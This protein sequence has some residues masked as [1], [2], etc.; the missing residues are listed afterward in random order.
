MLVREAMTT[1]VVTVTPQITLR[2]AARLL[3]EHHI[4]SM[5]VLDEH[6]RLLGVVS[7]ADVV[8]ESLL[9]DQR[10]HLL[11][12]PVDEGPD[13]AYVGEVMTTLPVTVRP[14]A[15][16][17]EAIRLMTDATVKSLPVTQHDRVVGMVSRTDVVAQLAHRDQ[18]VQAEVDELVRS[19]G[20]DWLVEVVDGVVS[21]EGPVSEHE[22]RL[23]R[24]L[25]GSVAGVTGIRFTA[26][27]APQGR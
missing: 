15:D 23:A 6:G 14:D 13:A 1:E 12:V 10:A 3:A 25:A 8:R 26:E 5:P 7:E 18:Q 27:S 11:L 22:R 24:A 21:F 20:L 9:P 19:E 17:A 16:L 2:H 4:T